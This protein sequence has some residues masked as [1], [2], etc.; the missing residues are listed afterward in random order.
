MT[1]T[2]NQL[3][4]AVD[5][6]KSEL[7]RELGVPRAQISHFEARGYIDEKYALAAGRMAEEYGLGDR[8]AVAWQV[9]IEA[10]RVRGRR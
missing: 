7:A 6:N 8:R 5:G 2:Y 10:D 4:L 3:L 9:L 1:R